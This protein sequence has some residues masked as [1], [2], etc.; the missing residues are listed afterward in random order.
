MLVNYPLPR[1]RGLGISFLS[2]ALNL[3]HLCLQV[4]QLTEIDEFAAEIT[5]E[6]QLVEAGEA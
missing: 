1:G 6:E 3:N 4:A 2:Y 5:I